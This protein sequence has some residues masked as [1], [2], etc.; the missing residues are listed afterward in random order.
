M[1]ADLRPRKARSIADSFDIAPETRTGQRERPFLEMPCNKSVTICR[2]VSILGHFVPFFLDARRQMNL[3][4]RRQ[5]GRS[6]V[7]EARPDRHMHPD[8]IDRGCGRVCRASDLILIR[9]G[10]PAHAVSERHL[11]RVA[12]TRAA[13]HDRA[14]R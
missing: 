4:D 2:D 7:A 1:S 5:P 6:A 9:Y 10:Q 14:D 8:R 13:R 12:L 3:P 11:T